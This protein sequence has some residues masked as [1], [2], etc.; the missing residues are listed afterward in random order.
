MAFQ[1]IHSKTGATVVSDL[2]DKAEWN[3]LDPAD[4]KLICCYERPVMKISSLGTQFFAHRKHST[5]EEVGAEHDEEVSA[6]ESERH[7]LCKRLIVEAAREIGWD[8]H[9][10]VRDPADNS[11]WVAD[12][13]HRNGYGKPI[14]IEVQLSPQPAHLYKSRQER[15]RA[16]GVR[17]AWLVGHS[18]NN[19]GMRALRKSEVPIF[20]L[21]R[22]R[23]KSAPSVTIMSFSPKGFKTVEMPLSQFV[24]ALL[25][26]EVR[27]A[28][29]ALTW[30]GTCP[31]CHS[32][33]LFCTE[34]SQSAERHSDQNVRP[35][36]MKVLAEQNLSVAMRV[37][38][39][40]RTPS[41]KRVVVW[42]L[43]CPTCKTESRV[44]DLSAIQLPELTRLLTSTVLDFDWIH[45]PSHH[46]NLM[47]PKEDLEVFPLPRWLTSIQQDGA[48]HRLSEQAM[49]A[50]RRIIR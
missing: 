22:H 31:S 13:L 5:C 14:A 48:P 20:P 12:T 16:S 4:L 9:E 27:Q 2:V 45:V 34:G 32:Q 29:Q 1:A 15:Y 19:K 47:V 37:P 25:S 36:M 42:I 44:K 18:T 30:M 23:D 50:L 40:F 38:R 26:R 7:K 33:F 6:L 17:A 24:Q 28:I 35:T 10:E 11:A 21:S 43:I 8:S 39:V 49:R 3:A 41:R 46:Q